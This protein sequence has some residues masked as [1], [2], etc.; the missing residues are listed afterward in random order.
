M[1]QVSLEAVH[2]LVVEVVHSEVVETTT[3]SIVEAEVVIIMEDEV[4]TEDEEVS[5]VEVVDRIS[6]IIH[7]REMYT[8]LKWKVKITIMMTIRIQIMN[9]RCII[10]HML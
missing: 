7:S 1:I 9:M 5:I 6:T 8:I 10:S 3:I 4:I 2:Q